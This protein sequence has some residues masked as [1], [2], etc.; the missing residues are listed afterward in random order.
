MPPRPPSSPPPKFRGVFRTD[1]PARAVYSEAAGIGRAWPAGVAVP[2]DADDVATLVRWAHDAG[3]ALIPRGSGSSMAGGAIGGGVIVDL[4]RLRALS[5][6]DA[7]ARRI[8]AG[9]GVLRG[10]VARAAAAVGLRFPVDPSSGE[11]CTVGGMASTNAAGPH[12]LQQGSTRLWVSALECVFDDGT[13]A[14]VKRGDKAP[15]VDAI[16]RFT[17]IAQDRVLKAG[18]DALARRDVRKD[19]SGY[20]LAAYAASRDLVDLMVGSEGTL[21]IVTAVELALAPSPGATTS[22]LLAFSDLDR[23]VE[24]AVSARDAGAAACELLDRTFLSIASK[25][26]KPLPAPDDSEAV[27]LIEIEAATA[28][29][30]ESAAKRLLDSLRRFGPTA[31]RPAFDA[32]SEAEL[33]EFRHAASPAIARMD[34]RY[35]SMQFIED[36]ALPPKSVAAYVR[37]VRRIL[38]ENDT[39][40]VIFG[41]A[42]DAHIHVNPLVDVSDPGWRARV[43]RI[44]R[45]VTALVAEL[46]GTLSGEHGDGRI[47]APLLSATWSAE[48][49]EL[50]ALVKH[51]FDPGGVFNPG[52]K[53]PLKG[54]SAIGDVKYDPTLP[55]LPEAARQA[56]DTVERD[57]AYS[58]LRLD[59][60]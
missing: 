20:G 19:S 42:G 41:H 49:L 60:L 54:Q 15:S 5:A 37:G 9:A 26:G 27:L 50:F 25:A 35:K 56:L 53:V 17:R 45:D 29:D 32:M 10:E 48:A 36:A 52:A 2:V 59:L 47:R 40:V 12:S 58:R 30:A 18:R 28:A 16:T 6:P 51:T 46:G 11:F 1:E 4:S 33:W 22:L 13:R 38:E 39:A 44:L 43:E 55:A 3:H 7:S 57:R 14:T 34:R 24:A 8:R 21:A 31:E 23:A